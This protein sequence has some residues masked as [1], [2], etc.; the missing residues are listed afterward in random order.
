MLFMIIE[1]FKDN[2]MLPIYRRVLCNLFQ[3]KEISSFQ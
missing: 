2:D 3:D 1:R